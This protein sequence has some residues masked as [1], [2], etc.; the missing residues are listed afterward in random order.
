MERMNE[1]RF[2]GRVGTLN[3][4]DK[5]TYLA[6][7]INESYKPKDKTE[8][9]EKPVWCD[10]VAFGPNRERISK[11]GIG[12]GDAVLVIGKLDSSEYEGKRK[13]SIV[14]NKIQLI[15]KAKPKGDANT[16]VD[17]V[18]AAATGSPDGQSKDTSAHAEAVATGA[19]GADLPF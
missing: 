7:A 13:T 8:W 3:A 4:G 5:H 1:V 6:L 19:G 15:E 18:T 2:I 11:Q 14:M 12:I 10:V 17:N 9:V 16:N